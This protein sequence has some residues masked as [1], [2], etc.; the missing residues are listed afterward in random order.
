MRFI[1]SRTHTIIGVIVALA[2]IFAPN[3]FGFSDNGGA[4]ANLPRIM[5]IILL[6]SELITASG[7]SLANMISMRTHLMLDYIAGALLAVSP[8]LFGFADQG[9]NAWLPHLIVGLMLIGSAAMT[10]PA[11]APDGGNL[12]R[13]SRAHA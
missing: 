10:D 9:T 12:H 6:G 11:T 4:A 8:W 5:G 13:G 7:L 1:S 2:L 3:I